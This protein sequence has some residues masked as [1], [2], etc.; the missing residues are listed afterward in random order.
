MRTEI[1]KFKEGDYVRS[2]QQGES[3]YDCIGRIS[4]KKVIGRQKIDSRHVDWVDQ[5]L[6]SSTVKTRY[7]VLI[8]PPPSPSRSGQAP[9]DSRST[10]GIEPNGSLKQGSSPT[11]DETTA[12]KLTTSTANNAPPVTTA[13]TNTSTSSAT[14]TLETPTEPSTA[15]ASTEAKIPVP[16]MT[17]NSL[18]KSQQ[19]VLYITRPNH[20]AVEGRT[21][22]ID[23]NRSRQQKYRSSLS[24]EEIEKR[25]EMDRERKRLSRQRLAAED[26]ERLRSIDRERKRTVRQGLAGEK[27]EKAKQFD[28]ERKRL[29]RQKLAARKEISEEV[30]VNEELVVHLGQLQSSSAK[31]VETEQIPARKRRRISLSKPSAEKEGKKDETARAESA[32]VQSSSGSG[33]RGGR[34]AHD[35]RKTITSH[36]NNLHSAREA[37]VSVDVHSSSGKEGSCVSAEGDE[38]NKEDEGRLDAL[39]GSRK[40]R[41][42]KAKQIIPRKG[43]KGLK[44]R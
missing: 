36:D 18:T 37:S 40:G 44:R 27:L 1:G 41:Q 9:E 8:E 20:S 13:V 15:S 28:R 32:V 12:I 14:T 16:L 21:I 42:T 39:K 26:L 17:L 5:E 43:K 4:A 29:S 7:L 19:H 11:S 33:G 23:A 2:I 25:R 34:G 24:K 38:V 31:N 6:G 30:S 3:H 10:P 22:R 35:S